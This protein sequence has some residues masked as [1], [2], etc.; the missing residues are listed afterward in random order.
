MENWRVFTE[1]LALKPENLILEIAITSVY[2]KGSPVTKSEIKVGDI[3]SKGLEYEIYLDISNT[4][5]DYERDVF[6]TIIK[7]CNINT[8]EKGLEPGMYSWEIRESNP[9]RPESTPPEFGSYTKERRS[10]FCKDLSQ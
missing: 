7:N 6:D 10:L 3:I 4:I 8:K 9:Q 2:G 5:K 1:Q